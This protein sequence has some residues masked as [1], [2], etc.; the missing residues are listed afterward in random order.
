MVEEGYKVGD[1]VLSTTT[2]EYGI[3]IRN[4]I[5]QTFHASTCSNTN[6]TR[7]NVDIVKWKRMI[8]HHQKSNTFINVYTRNWTKAN[9]R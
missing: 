5:F 7:K 6:S 2:G 8:L 3:V 9:A 4:N 1:L